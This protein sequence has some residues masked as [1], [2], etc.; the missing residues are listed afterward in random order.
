MNN[1]QKPLITGKTPQQLINACLDRIIRPK[2]NL[3]G[4]SW[5][6]YLL[7]QSI[8]ILMGVALVMTLTVL[9]DLSPIVIALLLVVIVLLVVL[10][11]KSAELLGNKLP[12]VE[13]FGK[14]LPLIF[15]WA[16]SGI[17]HYQIA[18]MTSA[19]GLLWLLK[20]PVLPYLDA[21][22][23]GLSIA[24]V[25]GRV[26][27]FMVG[28]CHGRPFSLGGMY[29][30]EHLE[31]GYVNYLRGVRLFPVQLLESVWLLFI[32]V[33]ALVLNLT[34]KIPGEAFSWY[35]VAYG[36]GRF[37]IEFLRADS[38]RL[39]LYGFSE[40][41]WVALLLMSIMVILEL[42]TSLNFHVW[43]AA[44]TLF[45]FSVVAI[46]S[47][48]R[49][50]KKLERFELLQ[51]HHLREFAEMVSWLFD[52]AAEGVAIAQDSSGPTGSVEAIT[53][54]HVRLSAIG[55]DGENGR[56]FQYSISYQNAT[57]REEIARSLAG[58][59]RQLKHPSD[60]CEIVENEPGIF[61]LYFHH[62]I[63]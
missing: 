27:C 4:R 63:S 56:N 21:L 51:P 8:G 49:R 6:A 10:I 12:K 14:P 53:S 3:L 52:L 25:N 35:I 42:T 57:M 16:G 34:G 54:R 7:W 55:I 28:C 19:A 39:Y 29:G 40:S 17:Y 30:D 22:V 61:T 11:F 31:A 37:L 24:Q 38:I 1:H 62:P 32:T 43:H 20:V 58:L 60:S 41:Q 18:I 45:L 36:F 2:V 23:I 26:G 48:M 44:A 5:N 50:F 33:I 9:R 13:I 46:V 47:L 59:I 15:I